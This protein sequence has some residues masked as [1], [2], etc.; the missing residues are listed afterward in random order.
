M[1]TYILTWYI[2]SYMQPR[3]RTQYNPRDIYIY[4]VINSASGRDAERVFSSTQTARHCNKQLF[5]VFF[6]TVFNLQGVKR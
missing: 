1:G 3:K 2:Y 4:I 6:I 5:A